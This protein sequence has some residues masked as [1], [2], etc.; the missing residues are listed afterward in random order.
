MRWVLRGGCVAL[1]AGVPLLAGI[2][3]ALAL[4]AVL[5]VAVEC[6]RVA[7]ERPACIAA[8]A[9]L[10]LGCACALPSAVMMFLA[11]LWCFAGL[12]M[13]LWTEDGAVRRGTAWAGICAAMICIG[14]AWANIHGQGTI[15]SQLAEHLTAWV[16][17]RDNAGDIL[18]RCYQLGFSRLEEDMQPVVNL[19]GTLVMTR[20]VRLE[21]LYSLRTTLEALLGSLLPQ[22]LVGWVLVTAVLT[23]ALPDMLRRKRGRQGQLAPFGAWQLDDVQRRCLNGLALGYLLSLM[24]T[25]AVMSLLGELC[26]AVFQYAYMLLGLAAMEGIT[27]RYGTARPLRRLWMAAC[28]VLAPVILVIL[29]IADGALDLRKLRRSTEDEGGIQQ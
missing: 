22:A 28:L 16:D 21:L 20:Q 27:R 14:L 5:P 11:S 6:C 23:A 8:L 29:G 10:L 24:A 13:C 12:G 1:A 17:A 25:T 19:L 3:G 4:L 18:L 7:E 15:F 26:A 9:A 2:P